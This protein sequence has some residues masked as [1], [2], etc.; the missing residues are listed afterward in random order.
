ME[1]TPGLRLPP[2]QGEA[3]E[4]LQAAGD[5]RGMNSEG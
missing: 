2:Q 3:G 1:E 5:G 4:V